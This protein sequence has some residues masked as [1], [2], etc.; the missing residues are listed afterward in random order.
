M[1]V[2]WWVACPEQ[3]Q[4]ADV[5]RR[6]LRFECIGRAAHLSN[7]NIHRIGQINYFPCIRIGYNG[8]I[9]ERTDCDMEHAH[10]HSEFTFSHSSTQIFIERTSNRCEMEETI[11]NCRCDSFVLFYTFVCCSFLC[12]VWWMTQLVFCFVVLYFETA[13]L[14]DKSYRLFQFFFLAWLFV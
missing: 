8:N 1:D 3:N 4:R 9:I 2:W 13:T 5:P 12:F 14:L 6:T 7:V 10:L 11:L